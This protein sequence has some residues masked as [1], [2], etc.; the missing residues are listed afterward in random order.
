MI[1]I[2]ATKPR[3]KPQKYLYIDEWMAFLNLTDEEVGNRLGRGRET[4]WRWRM[5]KRKVTPEKQAE[6]ARGLGIRPAQLWG[7]PTERSIDN[8][9]A[10]APDSVRQ[11]TYDVAERLHKK[12]N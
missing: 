12:P 3:S 1:A 10:D 6:L 7:P 2:M 9:L 5:E 4:V 8:L 11:A